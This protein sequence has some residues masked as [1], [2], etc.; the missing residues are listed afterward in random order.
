M[1]VPFEPRSWVSGLE[2]NAMMRRCSSRVDFHV[3]VTLYNFVYYNLH[4][5]VWNSKIIASMAVETGRTTES[6]LVHF[7]PFQLPDSLEI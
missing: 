6:G 7:T 2:G 5:D 1:D 3:I 4:I